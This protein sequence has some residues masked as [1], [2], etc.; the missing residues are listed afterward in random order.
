M[1]SSVWRQALMRMMRYIQPRCALQIQP[2]CRWEW[3]DR[4][5][6]PGQNPARTF[7]AGYCKVY[8]PGEGGTLELTTTRESGVTRGEAEWSG[9]SSASLPL[10]TEHDSQLQLLCSGSTTTDDFPGSLRSAA[11][12]NLRY[13]LLILF[14]ALHTPSST[15]FSPS[16]PSPFSPSSPTPTFFSPRHPR[17]NRSFSS[18]PP[19]FHSLILS[20]QRHKLV[21]DRSVLIFPQR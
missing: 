17:P 19:P 2:A 7:P 21:I 18:F 8:F 10:A 4:S 12:P 5:G 16:S 3:I 6:P 20:A 11:R 1:G 15:P 14:R 13:F 9:D